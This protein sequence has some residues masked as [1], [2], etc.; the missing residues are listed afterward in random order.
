MSLKVTV[1]GSGTSH[2]VPMI[3]CECAVC[4]STDPRDRRTRPSIL[5]ELD[6]VPA[7]AS[8]S[9]TATSV[10]SILVDTSTDLRFQALAQRVARVDA[11]LFTHSHADHIFGLDEVRR[12]NIIQRSA[13]PFYADA[14]TLADVQRAFAYIFAPGTAVGGGIPQLVPFRLGG[15]F[16]L[17]GQE[18]VPVPLWHGQRPILGFR[19]GRFAYLT[20]CNAI[21][22]TSWPLLEGVELLI[23]DALRR[24]KHP[25]HF[26]VDEAI[27]V[28]ERLRPQ[29]AWFTHICHDLGHAETCASLP[30]GVELA[31]DGML[32]S[33]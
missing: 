23:V 15:P 16:S 24:K 32:L 22:E 26:N 27:A 11:I 2:G 21:P 33:V 20:D 18:I 9:A 3:G 13:I 30:S 8:G 19:I 4:Q 6:G 5:L 25:T 1:L 31:Y 14:Q 10:R 7:D 17:G 28:V 29:R 12:F